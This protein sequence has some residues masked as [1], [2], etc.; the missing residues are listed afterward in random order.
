M[1]S[2]TIVG[3][4]KRKVLYLEE[5]PKGHTPEEKLSIT[6]VGSQERT[7]EV[8]TPEEKLGITIDGDY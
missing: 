8:Q 6:T 7:P 2:I 1:L 3:S 5:R 4:T